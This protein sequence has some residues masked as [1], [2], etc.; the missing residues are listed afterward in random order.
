MTDL[1][2]STACKDSNPLFLIVFLMA[3]PV[4]VDCFEEWVTERRGTAEIEYLGPAEA[5]LPYTIVRAGGTAWLLPVD[6]AAPAV[7]SVAA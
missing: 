7:P 1:L 3:I 2:L 6:G 5:A 4:L